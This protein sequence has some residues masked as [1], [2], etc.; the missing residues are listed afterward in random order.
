M[1]QGSELESLSARKES[2]GLWVELLDS[3]EWDRPGT[4]IVDVEEG[5]KSRH[6]Q[7]S[8]VQG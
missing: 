7:S 5:L 1:K 6:C 3:G 2:I 8:V 4:E